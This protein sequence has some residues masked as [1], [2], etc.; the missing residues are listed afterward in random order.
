MV[1]KNTLEMDKLR[2]QFV[3]LFVTGYSLFEYYRSASIPDFLA[4]GCIIPI[5]CTILSWYNYY[6]IEKELKQD[7]DY[8]KNQDEENETQYQDNNEHQNEPNWDEY[9]QWGVVLEETNTTKAKD[10]FK[11]DQET[12]SDGEVVIE[13]KI[14]LT[15]KNEQEDKNI[16]L[17]MDE[18]EIIDDY[19][20]TQ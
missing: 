19:E 14:V 12:E 1:S 16:I 17:Q 2:L 18:F 8:E 10:S 3:S 20:L 4:T 5:T 11:I 6:E 9:Y 7:I 13:T 15:N